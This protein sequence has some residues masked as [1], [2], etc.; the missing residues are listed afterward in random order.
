MRFLSICFVALLCSGW[1]IAQTSPAASPNA[2][3]SGPATGLRA[4]LASVDIT[5]STFETM[6]GYTNRRCGIAN[7][8]H[9]RLFAKVLY[10]EATGAR[11]AIV[12]MDLGS[13]ESKNL[14]RRVSAELGIPL[15]LLAPSHTHSAPRF[16]PPAGSEE[17]PTA[18]LAELENKIFAAVK[19]AAAAP[20]PA[21]LSSARGAIQLGYLRLLVREDGRARAVFDNLE[22]IPY[23]P[24]DPEFQLLQ[25]NDASGKPRA[26]LVHYAAHPVVL[27]PTSC[28]Y[29]ADYPGV[30]QARVETALPGVQAMFVQGAAGSINPLFQGRTGDLEKDFATM[31][32]MGDLLAAEVLRAL[33]AIRPLEDR[34]ASILFRT[35]QLTFQDRWEDGKTMTMG[36]STVLINGQVAIAAVPGEPFLGMQSMWKRNADAA[37]PL[38]YGYTQSTPDPWP[39][40]IPDIRSA[41]LGGYGADTSTKIEVGSAERIMDYHL[42]Q[43][44]DLQGMWRK[45]PGR[46]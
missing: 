10:L 2:V 45:L 12:T 15:L 42:M 9:D 3:P 41:A 27:G 11:M 24:V 8:T 40:Y 5:P 1:A 7:G 16:L 19:Q 39:G 23:G 33:P 38:F 30:V 37:L 18:Y 25:V 28:L 14:F 6:Y 20:F 34:P 22:R 31:T 4:G 21:T 26:L 17:S 43:L 35:R 32:K 36:I 29:S 46:P 13:I 44:Y